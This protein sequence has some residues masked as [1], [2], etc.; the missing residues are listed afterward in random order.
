MPLWVAWSSGR[1]RPKRFDFGKKIPHGAVTCGIRTRSHATYGQKFG[2]A[3]DGTVC[4]CVGGVSS[5]GFLFM[6]TASRDMR[7]CD[8][9][10]SP[11]EYSRRWAAL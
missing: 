5:T 1:T 2:V 7:G 11:P 6:V 8:R 9:G 4:T 3:A 10:V